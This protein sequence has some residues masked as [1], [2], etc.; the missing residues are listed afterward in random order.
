MNIYGGPNQN[1]FKWRGTGIKK[2]KKEEK[3]TANLFFIF[4]IFWRTMTPAGPPLPP[5]LN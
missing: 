1:F 2:K 4:Y 5:S 3:F